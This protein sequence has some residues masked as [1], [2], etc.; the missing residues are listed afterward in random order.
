MKI[1]FKELHHLL[2]TLLF[3]DF[4]IINC[5]PIRTNNGLKAFDGEIYLP[6]R[7]FSISYELSSVMLTIHSIPSVRILYTDFPEVKQ[8]FD[9][10][11][12]ETERRVL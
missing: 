2:T 3:E 4:K 9:R 7:N 8:T 11:K 1:K 10:M 12:I 6:D 5:Q